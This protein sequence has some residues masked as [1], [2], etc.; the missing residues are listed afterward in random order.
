VEELPVGPHLGSGPKVKNGS[1]SAKD[2]ALDR[3]RC[4]TIQ[5][6]ESC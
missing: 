3:L 5:E 4:G 2:I 1:S 6:E